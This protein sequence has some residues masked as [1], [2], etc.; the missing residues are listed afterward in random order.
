MPVDGVGLLR[1][2]FMVTD[3]LQAGSIPASCLE[4]GEEKTFV[5]SMA[6][7]LAAHHSGVRATARRVSGASTS[8]PTSSRTSRGATSSSPTRRTR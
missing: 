1:A 6:K 8:A 2:E 7:S 5:D 3:A 4:R